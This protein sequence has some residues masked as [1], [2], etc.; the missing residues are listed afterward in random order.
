M[1]V[2]KYM[3]GT[4]TVV[5]VDGDLDGVTAAE[6]SATLEALT[7]DSG[8][9]LLDLG[10]VGYLSSAGL[11]V[12]LLVYYRARGHGVPLALATMPEE[13][14]SVLA[15]TGFLDSVLV[16]DNVDDAIRALAP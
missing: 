4:V 5:V 8:Q 11:R 7:P 13:A 9:L 16:A 3:R 10:R 6:A 1:Q 12:L 14:R 2:E 15:A